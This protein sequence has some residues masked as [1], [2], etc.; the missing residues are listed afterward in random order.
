MP[1]L[2]KPYIFDWKRCEDV[3]YIIEYSIT[4]I[5]NRNC[6]AC[7]HLAP[8]AKIPNFVDVDE[9]IK[10]TDIMR[11]LIP[12]AHTFWLTG[13][14]PTL[15]PQFMQ[16]LNILREIY[17]DTTVGIYSNGI[18]LKRYEHDEAF[19]RYIKNAGIVWAVTNYDISPQYFEDLFGSR[20]CTNN[21]T[22]IQSGKMFFK[23]TNYSRN[24]PIT[25][26]KYEKCGW[27]RSKLNI[28]NGRIYN[29]PMA[30]FADLFN[31]YFGEGLVVSEDDYLV[32]DG[33]LTRERIDAFRR[34][35]PFCS[36]CDLSKR[37]KK[38]FKNAQSCKRKDEW[39][40][41]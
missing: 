5:C 19:W 28:R 38:V 8:L 25:Q 33:T 11:K 35:T 1:E 14:E 34:P 31:A 9:F 4:D 24:Q 20:G 16:F 18:T 15:H 2:T 6:T 10:V 29:C 39:S 13:G 41:L 32:V 40:E 7:S 37:Y 26:E 30:E 12:D 21:L 23:L 36:H 27:E 17:P 3:P 22:I